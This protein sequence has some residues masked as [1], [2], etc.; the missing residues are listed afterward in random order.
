L[1]DVTTHWVVAGVSATSVVGIT[2][3][4]TRARERR[5]DMLTC[6]M[7]FLI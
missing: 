7:V 2:E 4:A 5:F 1:A 6:I 3:K